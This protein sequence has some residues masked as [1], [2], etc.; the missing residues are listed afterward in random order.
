MVAKEAAS[1]KRGEHE[2][3]LDDDARKAAGIAVIDLFADL[4]A[5][6]A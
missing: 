5:H 6:M 2:S 1:R 4:F 3:H